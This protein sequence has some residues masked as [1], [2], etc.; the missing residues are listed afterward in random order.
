MTDLD[1]VYATVR[2]SS[3]RKFHDST[4]FFTP[5][6]SKVWNCCK[7]TSLGGQSAVLSTKTG[8]MMDLDAVLVY[9]LP[10]RDVPSKGFLFVFV[11]CFI[12]WTARCRLS[13]DA[14]SAS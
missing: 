12:F 13:R 5:S 1:A 2:L 10:P 9:G 14:D 8:L 4:A 3:N 7:N 6:V 11:F